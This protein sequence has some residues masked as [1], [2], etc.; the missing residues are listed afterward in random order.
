MI[1]KLNIVFF[2]QKQSSEQTAEQA[3]PQEQRKRGQKVRLLSNFQIERYRFVRTVKY[4]C[5]KSEKLHTINP[6]KITSTL[7]FYSFFFT[8]FNT[9]FF[10][11]KAAK[12]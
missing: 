10:V 2:L 1:T 4:L 12:D 5:F 8:F 9:V 11:G 6:S 3:Q 7:H